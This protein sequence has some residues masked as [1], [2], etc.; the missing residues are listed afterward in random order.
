MAAKQFTAA[1]RAELEAERD[2]AIDRLLRWR[3]SRAFRARLVA[4]ILDLNA[5]I[6][7]DLRRAE[8]RE[9]A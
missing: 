7:A 2:A 4:L 3:D 1:H 6:V 9:R 5:R 8:R